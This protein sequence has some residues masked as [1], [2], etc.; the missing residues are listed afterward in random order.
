MYK[1]KLNVLLTPL[2][3]T[4]LTACGGGGG[5]TENP[6]PETPTPPA[7]SAP[8]HNG[9]I[10][11][12]LNESDADLEINLLQGSA[13]ADGDTLSISN[14]TANASNP[15]TGVTTSSSTVSI[16]PATYADLVEGETQTIAYTFNISDGKSTTPRSLTVTVN[17]EGAATTPPVTSSTEITIDLNTQQFYG[18][19]STLD[20]TKFLNVHDTFTNSN[21]TRELA[22][23]FKNNYRADHGRQ[24]WSPLSQTVVKNQLD[25]D[26]TYPTTAT[27]I[28]N[29]ASNISNYYNNINS[30]IASNRVVVTDHP[31]NPMYDNNEP[32]D[33]ARWAADYF[34]HYYDDNSRPL[35]YEPMN[36]P[37]VHAGEYKENY[38]NSE[39]QTREHMTQ[40]FAEIGKEFDSRPELS[41]V[42]VIGFASA[43]PSLELWDFGHWESRM[44]MFMDNA[45]EHMD[46]FS[47][48]L[49]DGVNVV[50]A[51]SAR[52]GSNSKA[53]LDLIETYSMFKWDVVKPHAIT[54]Y[55]AIV[56]RPA[57]VIEYDA[58]VNSQTIK[59]FN[60][61][62]LE[63]ME[64]E[65]RI[66]TSIPFITG[67]STWYWQNPSQGNGH[68]YNPSMWRPNPDNIT[69][70]TSTNRWEFID[71]NAADNYLENNNM[72]FLEFWKDVEGYRANISNNDPDTQVAT[73][74]NDDK[75]YIIVSNLE[76]EQKDISINLREMLGYKYTSIDISRLKVP[77][78]EGATLTTTSEVT[79]ADVSGD[80][81]NIGTLTL[82]PSETVKLVVTLDKTIEN[83]TTAQRKTYYADE[84]L[85]TITANQAITFTLNGVDVTTLDADKS[86]ASLRM[87]IGRDHNKSKQ[88]TLSVNGTQ[89]T[90]PDDWAGYD[91]ANRDLFFGTIDVPVPHNLLSENNTVSITFSDAGGRI[92]STVLDVTNI[93]PAIEVSSI[94]LGNDITLDAS[95]TNQISTSVMPSGVVNA[96]LTWLSSDENIA[97]VSENGLV[98]AIGSG[99]ATIT[100]SASN[101][102]NDTVSVTVNALDPNL[103]SGLESTFD[104]AIDSA[105]LFARSETSQLNLATFSVDAVAAKDGASGLLVDTT[106]G[107]LKLQYA[108]LSGVDQTKVYRIAFDAKIVSGQATLWINTT[109]AG[110]INKTFN[111]ATT[112]WQSMSLDIPAGKLG[113]GVFPFNFHIDN[114][115]SPGVVYIDNVTLTPVE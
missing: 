98:T 21:Y 65:D 110:W 96:E 80:A 101:G 88:P 64:R 10:A 60:H 45:G 39:E 94:E 109:L 114:L 40:W 18:N 16:S 53:I 37:F 63:L 2:A 69:L 33:G 59:S 51:N 7:N 50:G 29:G 48:H 34:T 85:Q 56:D 87:G 14:L 9:N 70:N 22:E 76:W 81:L 79:N 107:G 77:A 52:S 100:A 73:F 66:L 86:T 74:I 71:P 6:T 106:N 19:V 41:N 102:I 78:D 72:L 95:Q 15:S 11:V 67:H 47:V 108:N 23:N 104:G 46:A 43:W 5:S 115:G 1:N 84:H 54:E 8:T 111:N 20:R 93:I 75:A 27:A 24:F 38:N 32:I 36:E 58:T 31:A 61:I 89:V 4:V 30:D 42:S 49:Y 28:S 112:D 90:V 103:I 105:K 44:K 55:G 3:I 113:T 17:G 57:G 91:Q 68:P 83:T 12:S 82:D 26:G 35:F 25:A 62:M 13:D 92:S 97:T 99:S